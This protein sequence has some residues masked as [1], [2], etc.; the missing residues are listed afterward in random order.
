MLNRTPA[1]AGARGHDAGREAGAADEV[2]AQ[3]EPAHEDPGTQFN[4]KINSSAP[5]L[6][7]QT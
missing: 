7:L 1:G 6:W 3:G 4:R 5:L 2:Q